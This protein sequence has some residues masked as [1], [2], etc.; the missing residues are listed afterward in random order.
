M[1]L[2]TSRFHMLPTASSTEVWMSYKVIWGASAI[3][4]SQCQKF[5][6]MSPGSNTH[7]IGWVALRTVPR[8]VA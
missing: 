1:S 5:T 2:S 4:D 6:R 8:S 3:S 7:S